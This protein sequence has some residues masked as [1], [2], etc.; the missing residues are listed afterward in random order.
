ML[1]FEELQ[2]LF[3]SRDII[4]REQEETEWNQASYYG[5]IFAKSGGLAEAVTQA[6][7]ELDIHDFEF[8][9]IVCDGIDKCKQALAR[10]D[11]GVLPNNFI[12]GMACIGGCVGGSG[13]LVRYNDA[14]EEIEEHSE[15][16]T[17]TEILPNVRKTINIL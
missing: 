6:L 9:P 10:A 16:A 4:L 12:E 2:A 1:T 7:K 17:A 11:K 5:R 13:N 3:D 14:A 15:E 8:N